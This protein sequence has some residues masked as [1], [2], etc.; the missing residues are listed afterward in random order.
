MVFNI[1][2]RSRTVGVVVIQS[3]VGVFFG[4]TQVVSAS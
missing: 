2:V 3:S 4:V 1:E